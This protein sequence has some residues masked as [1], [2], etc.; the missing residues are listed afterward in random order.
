MNPIQKLTEH[1]ASLP[2]IGPRQA[3]RIV[4]HLLREKKAAL[5]DMA[6]S[7]SRLQ[8]S[9]GVCPSCF[10]YFQKK[11]GAGDACS[12]CSDPSRD[13]SSM[14]VVSRDADLDNIERSRA[15]KGLY[16]VLGGSVPLLEQEPEKS[17]RQRELVAAAESRAADGTLKEIIFAMNATPEGENTVEHLSRVLGPLAE[18]RG[19]KISELGRGLSTGSELE[20]SDNET[21]KNALGNRR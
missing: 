19:V 3:K 18:S 21:L 7:L 10:R 11:A 12:I 5:L 14:L 20:Y 17:I 16:F 2:G 1:F 9:V 4:Y 8:D 13:R 15:Y 6:D